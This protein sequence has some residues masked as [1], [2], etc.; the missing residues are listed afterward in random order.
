MSTISSQ[1]VVFA[2]SE[3]I[4]LRAKGARVNDSEAVPNITAGENIFTREQYTF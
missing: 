3:M 4:S 1:C 2:E